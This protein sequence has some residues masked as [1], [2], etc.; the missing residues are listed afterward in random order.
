[1]LITYYFLISL[2]FIFNI[3][4]SQSISFNSQQQSDLLVKIISDVKTNQQE[5]QN[6]FQTAENVPI[7][8]NLIGTLNQ[9]KTYTDDSYISGLLT[10]SEIISQVD[11][12]ATQLPWYNERIA[13]SNI[14][15]LST[16]ANS[17]SSGSA[18]ASSG[19][20]SG[21]SS[22]SGN[23]GAPSKKIGLFDSISISLI[24]GLLLSI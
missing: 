5:Y 1:M 9:L 14:P 7:P 18:Q 17:G 13:D 11:N 16:T 15:S 12:I 8:L 2:S 20:G 19:S 22:N 23:S 21:S 4:N 24:C 6:F 3:T 10:N